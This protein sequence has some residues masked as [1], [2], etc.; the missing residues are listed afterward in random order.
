MKIFI[1]AWS[2]QNPLT[3][4]GQYVRYLTQQ[5][6]CLDA[7]NQYTLYSLYEKNPVWRTLI[8]PKPTLFYRVITKFRWAGLFLKAMQH[9]LYWPPMD[10]LLQVK[11]SDS[12]EKTIFFFPN[13]VKWPLRKNAKSVIVVHDLGFLLCPQYLR[14]RTTHLLNRHLARSIKN[15]THIITVSE[16]TKKEILA[17]Y[18]VTES[19]ISIITPAVA[20][21]V[22]NA[23]AQPIDA[24]IIEQ[25]QLNKPYLLFTGTLE[26]RKNIIGLLNAYAQLPCAL[27]EQYS[28]VL[29]GGKGW[30]DHEIHEKLAQLSHLDI[31]C[32]GYVPDDH[33]PAL[34]R[35]A[36]IFVYP[37]FYEGF[38]MPPLEA[39]ACGAPVITSCTTSLPEVVGSAGLL[40]DPEQTQS[41]VDAMILVLTDPTLA[42]TLRKE[43]LQQ[44]KKF[45]WQTSAEQLLAIFQRI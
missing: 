41:L 27:Q 3:G 2:L 16:N 14:A 35:G 17:H 11:D 39:M 12:H 32:I 38:G 7:N 1:D 5:L 37:S 13:F 45:S 30:L 33:L 20:T 40:I 34:Y 6:T 29:A 26:P 31:R 42:A 24:T 10:R 9:V 28:L 15:C 18:P 8:S 22:F 21:D 43:G 4:I 44:A 19:K 25:Y 36:S 23:I